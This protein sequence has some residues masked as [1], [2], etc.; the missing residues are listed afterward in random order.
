[1]K[2]GLCLAGGGV[3]AAAHIGAIKALEEE[4]INFEYVSGTSAGSIVAVLYSIGYSADEILELFKMYGKKIK[5]IDFKNILKIIYGVIL[6][7]KLII[8]GLNSGISIEKIV[9]KACKAKNVDDIRQIQKHLIIPCVDV[10]SGKLYVFNS[11]DIEIE[12]NKVKYIPNGNI[13]KIVR[14]SCSYPLVFSPCDYDNT[15][16]ID[17]GIKEN[18]PWK[19]TKRIGAE[20]VLSIIFDTNKKKCCS[21][22]IEIA[23]RTI[24]LICEEL[25]DYEL[26]GAD[27]LLKIKL[28]DVSLLDASKINKIYK[29][30]YY[31]TKE[32]IKKLKEFL[33]C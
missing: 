4:N 30:G 6:K 17:G 9:S 24:E 7:R 8:D 28:N 16:L 25:S 32:Q 11:D 19:E 18:V 29:E 13:G 3:K 22:V 15:Q 21:N 20:K 14:A 5:Y 10:H 1:M 27:Y 12:D 33:N 26:A 2:L 31:Q 23:S